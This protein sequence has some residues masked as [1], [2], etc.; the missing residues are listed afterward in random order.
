MS[1]VDALAVPAICPPTSGNRAPA[2]YW[3][4]N[5]QPFTHIG[6]AVY[7]DRAGTAWMT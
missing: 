3:S 5:V 1:T 2:G 6:I 4:S 7:R